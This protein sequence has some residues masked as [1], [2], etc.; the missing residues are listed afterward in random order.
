ML[1]FT[2][3][4]LF[5]YYAHVLNFYLFLIPLNAFSSFEESFELL[6]IFFF[7]NELLIIG[8]AVKVV[9]FG[10]DYYILYIFI[11]VFK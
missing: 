5:F 8:Y 7:N 10:N 4:F 3:I 11:V 1:F 9:F 2:V 6:V